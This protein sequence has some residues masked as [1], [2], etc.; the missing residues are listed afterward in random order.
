[1]IWLKVLRYMITIY[2]FSPLT[3]GGN[4]STN[5]GTTKPR[6]HS[7]VNA[8]FIDAMWINLYSARAQLYWL[9]MCHITTQFLLCHCT[10]WKECGWKNKQKNVRH[11]CRYIANL[12]YYDHNITH[13]IWYLP[14]AAYIMVSRSYSALGVLLPLNII[15]MHDYWHAL[16][17]KQCLLSI[18]CRECV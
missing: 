8:A 17:T 5:I 6:G 4:L 3:L 14:Y 10:T 7:L 18:S 12:W 1:M 2:A 9:N 11:T 13:S 15:M 16:S